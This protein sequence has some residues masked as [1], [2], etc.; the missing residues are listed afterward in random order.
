VSSALR[1]HFQVVVPNTF[2][3]RTIPNTMR[4]DVME[5][6]SAKEDARLLRGVTE[7]S[8]SW[9]QVQRH[10]LPHRTISSIR[11][12]YQRMTF[13]GPPG[14]N[15]CQRCGHLK[16]GHTCHREEEAGEED[17]V[18][19]LSPTPLSCPPPA[20]PPPSPPSDDPY[21]PRPLPPP[22]GSIP[23]FLLPPSFRGGSVLTLPC[24]RPMCFLQDD[25]RIMDRETI[26]REMG[27]TIDLSTTLRVHHVS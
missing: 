20:S 13:H 14:R 19:L 3:G 27:Y 21:G 10:R 11:N 9:V 18:L 25:P 5:P 4:H 22:A 16:K 7:F 23:T 26:L 2:R 17:V 1:G 8:R 12:R 15:R 24:D 6:W